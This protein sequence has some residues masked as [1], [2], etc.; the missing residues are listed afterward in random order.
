M[1]APASSSALR[2]PE[3][4]GLSLT[5][6]LL[7]ALFFGLHR[8]QNG[9]EITFHR[10]FT[11]SSPGEVY[12]WL[13]S[14]LL[15]GP[16]FLLLGLAWRDRLARAAERG[17]SW[18]EGLGRGERVA[19]GLGLLVL[20]TVGYRLLRL[21]VL[22]DFLVT[23]DEYGVRFGGQVWSTGRWL[24][25]LPVPETLMPGL[26]LYVRNG[27]ASSFDMPLQLAVS[28]LA[29]VSRLGAWVYAAIAAGTAVAVAAAGGLGFG[30]RAAPVAA[31]LFV[32]SPMAMCLSLTEHPQMV[33]RGLVALA[34][35][36]LIRASRVRSPGA[37]LLSG[38]VLGLGCLCRPFE[39]VLLLAPLAAALCWP[40]GDAGGGAR[41][42]AL[43]VAG[44][45]PLL[46]LQLAYNFH[47][48]GHLLDMTRIHG[49]ALKE[50]EPDLFAR[51]GMNISYNAVQL[52]IWFF[53]PIGLI[54][55]GVGA[56]ADRTARWLVAGVLLNLAA[57]MVHSNWGVH[58]V[59]PI[60]FS[61][62]AISLAL[63]ATAGALALRRGLEARQLDARCIPAAVLALALGAN[64]I[65]IHW[66]LRALG[67]LVR[68]QVLA[69]GLIEEQL[70]H[71]V[72]LAPPFE[73]VWQEIPPL[74]RYGSWVFAWRSVS[75][76]QDQNVII[77]HDAPGAAAQARKLFPGRGLYRL[78]I[79]QEPPFLRFA[80]VAGAEG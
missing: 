49:A 63:A 73:R 4:V 71:A 25:P 65:F 55:A 47:M 24:V 12:F 26:Y 57:S 33:S 69:Y 21:L 14:V 42:A 7:V 61:E 78:T 38:L 1:S 8:L 77:L 37:W 39:T 74:A 41:R 53:G 9:L 6:V 31:L 5:G 23:D 10:G 59:G 51:F 56:L 46:L 29:Q 40:R 48:T 28:A 30:R 34:I 2:P 70:S 64:T 52:A 72:L 62:C 80:P 58:V 13:G 17:L 43:L 15:L 45:L 76:R 60:H 19:C 36:L 35:G 54:L 44:A 50:A 3:R 22:S 67:V 11:N 32:L 20:L 75:P 79:L 16:G 66:Q 18:F 27:L 68:P